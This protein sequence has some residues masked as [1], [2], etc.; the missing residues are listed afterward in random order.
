MQ[1]GS[2]GST[3]LEG[4]VIAVV[5]CFPLLVIL[6]R[7]QYMK[8]EE[9]GRDNF[10]AQLMNTVFMKIY[11]LTVLMYVF[12]EIL[13]RHSAEGLIHPVV[14]IAISV[15]IPCVATAIIMCTTI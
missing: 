4:F 6:F 8:Q 15:V 7:Y 10:I 12:L 3:L 14:A 5:C 13:L 9:R 11:L 2:T 1:V